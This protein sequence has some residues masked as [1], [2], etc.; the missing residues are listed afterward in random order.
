M[1]TDLSNAA[2]TIATAFTQVK[3]PRG[4]LEIY[5]AHYVEDLAAQIL[6]E[7]EVGGVAGAHPRADTL[8][9]VYSFWKYCLLNKL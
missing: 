6:G 4:V 8:L 3:A 1:N 9:Q 7:D 5:F 2:T